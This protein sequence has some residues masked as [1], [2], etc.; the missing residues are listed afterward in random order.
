MFHMSICPKRH[1]R[2]YLILCFFTFLYFDNPKPNPSEYRHYN[3]SYMV[4]NNIFSYKS[5]KPC[6]EPMFSRPA[7]S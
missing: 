3:L 6:I 7:T 5:N 1:M 4:G 2:L